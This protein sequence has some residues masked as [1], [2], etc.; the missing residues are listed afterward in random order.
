[1]VAALRLPVRMIV[2]QVSGS[3]WAECPNGVESARRG[4]RLKFICFVLGEPKRIGTFL[5]LFSA[6]PRSYPIFAL[7]E[8][9][10]SVAGAMQTITD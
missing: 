7:L 8:Q 9:V 3:A 2:E 6:S 5:R 1:C 10:I 4:H